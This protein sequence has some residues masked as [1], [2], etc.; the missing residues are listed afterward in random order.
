MDFDDPEGTRRYAGWRAYQQSKLANL[1]F[2]YRFAERLGTGARVTANC[3]HP[4]F[5]ASRFGHNNSGLPGLFAMATQ[6]LFAISDEK[7]AVTSHYLA[8]DEGGGGRERSLLRQVPRDGRARP[9]RATA[10]RRRGCGR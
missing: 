10:G 6:R 1:L 8:T 2:T 4:G 7:G 5:V 9:P 3:L